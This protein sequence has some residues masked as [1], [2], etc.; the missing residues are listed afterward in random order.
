MPWKVSDEVKERTKFVLKWEE[1]CEASDD[2][3]VNIAELCRRFGISR[4][5]G[6]DWISR[7]RDSG[8]LDALAARSN[9]S[10]ELVV[11]RPCASLPRS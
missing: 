3:R 11:R 5:T 1:R 2:G 6:Y 4:Q 8:S 7:Y 10:H 9:A